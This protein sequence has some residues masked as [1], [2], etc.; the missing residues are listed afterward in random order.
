MRNH[1]IVSCGC[2]KAEILALAGHNRILDLTG[3]IFGRLTIL[4]DS[5]KRDT[6]GGVIWKCECTCGNITYVS[7]SNLTRK[8]EPTVSCGCAKSRGEETLIRLF[9]ENHIAFISQK[10]FPDCI[11]P[12]TNKYLY[13]DFYLPEYN[14]LIEYDGA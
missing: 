12:N 1:H 10:T 4:E 5:G 2:K 9:I 11:Y 8:Q 14:T 7:G 3:K 13:F 6:S